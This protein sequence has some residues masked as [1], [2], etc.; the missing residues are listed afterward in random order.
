MRCGSL[1]TVPVIVEPTR[2]SF[3]LATYNTNFSSADRDELKEFASFIK[4]LKLLFKELKDNRI[5]IAAT[6][7][8]YELYKTTIPTVVYEQPSH[9]V[10]KLAIEFIGRELKHSLRIVHKYGDHQI[11]ADFESLSVSK[12]NE[13]YDSE[14]Y[15]HW[16]DMVNLVFVNR[17]LP[18]CLKSPRA[19]IFPYSSG[20]LKDQKGNSVE[21]FI[22][23]LI[24]DVTD[25]MEF[26]LLQLASLLVNDAKEITCRGTGTHSS[27]WGHPISC[28]ADVPRFER[29]LLS[30]FIQIGLVR[31]ILFLSFDERYPV[32]AEPTLV[33]KSLERKGGADI[34]SCLLR[35]RGSKNNAQN[36]NIEVS[37]GYGE[38]VAK[39]FEN[40]I[41]IGKLDNL[42]AVA[43]TVQTESKT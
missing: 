8:L 33:V 40:E 27:M 36:V 15:F 22:S 3:N 43:A 13:L 1:N 10:Y 18:W 25:S 5:G 4:E 38:L 29:E 28:L 35:G 32:V 30:K 16:R 42:L 34:L 12:N 17:L 26:K 6:K 39:A 7:E 37:T 21:I 19:S 41:N 20:H 11:E 2:L 9:P 23:E 14:I 31:N 24:Q